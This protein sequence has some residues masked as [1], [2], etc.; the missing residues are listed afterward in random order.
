MPVSDDWNAAAVPWNVVRTVSGS[1]SRATAC[2]R[3][4][5]SPSDTP[6]ARLNEMVTEGSWP[7]CVIRSGPT[8]VF[9]LVTAFSGTSFPL[10]DRT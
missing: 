1:V 2:T 5:A 10:L 8:V 3:S 9:G 6:G 7:R 4:T